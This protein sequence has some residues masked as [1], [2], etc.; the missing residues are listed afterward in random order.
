MRL[1]RGEGRAADAC[2]A[3]EGFVGTEGGGEPEVPL[4]ASEPQL[5]R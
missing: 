5:R 1:E 2:A 3:A 4:V